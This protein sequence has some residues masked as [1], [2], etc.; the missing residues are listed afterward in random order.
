MALRALLLTQ[1]GARPGIDKLSRC[2]GQI[3]SLQ[4]S[5]GTE[6]SPSITIFTTN[7]AH[8]A[9]LICITGGASGAESL[10]RHGKEYLFENVVLL[11]LL[12]ASSPLIELAF[13]DFRHR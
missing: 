9:S 6:L 12:Q 10:K 8:K 3:K 2:Y 13:F 5:Q 4:L 1:L 11:T 7:S